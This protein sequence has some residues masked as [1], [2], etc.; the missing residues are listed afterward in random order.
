MKICLL[1]HAEAEPRGPGVAE[2][3]RQL[4]PNGKRELRAVLKQAREAGVDP[5]VILSSPWTRAAET[6]LAARDAFGCEQVIETKALLPD[7]LP[8]HIWGEIRS[9]RPL[10]EIMV[11]GHE[12]HLSRFAAFPAGGSRGHRYEEGRAAA[13]RGAGQRR[14]AA[15]R[16]EVDA[17]AETCGREI[18]PGG[19]PDADR[20]RSARRG[21][22][23]GGCSGCQRTGGDGVLRRAHNH[24]DQKILDAPYRRR[25]H[26]DTP[27]P[28]ILR[29]DVHDFRGPCTDVHG[30]L[31]P[32]RRERDFPAVG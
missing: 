10:K 2:A 23:A 25:Q 31:N 14:P 32:L 24:V 28:V 30:N 17:D 8:S 7:V 21:D 26:I 9:L 27:D 22:R 13:H 4:T 11:V 16:A 5:E 12:P 15:R 19:D 29:C 20:Q 3:A 6:A 18:V 1:R